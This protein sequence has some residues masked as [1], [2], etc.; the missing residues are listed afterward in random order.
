MCGQ[1]LD[2]ACATEKAACDSECLAIEACIETVCSHLSSI[3]SIEEGQCQVQ[4]QSLHLAGKQKHLALVNCA[5][6]AWPDC[7][8]CSSYPF[9]YEACVTKHSS[10]GGACKDE[11]DACNASNDCVQYRQ[12]VASCTT[13]AACLAC[14]DTTE[15]QNGSAIYFAYQECIAPHCIEESWL[16]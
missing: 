2:A 3:G 14:D 7:R 1:C 6:S 11:Y 13:L 10:D 16:P 15:G 4:C 5:I 9:D 8:A 12:C